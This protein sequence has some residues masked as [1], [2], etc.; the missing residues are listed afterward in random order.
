[1]IEDGKLRLP[2][3]L[4]AQTAVQSDKER[5]R[6]HRGLAAVGR[7][8]L[9]TPEDVSRSVTNGHENA[10]PVTTRQDETKREETKKKPAPR[11][12]RQDEDAAGL[13]PIRQ[14]WNEVAHAD[15]SRWLKTVGERKANAMARFKENPDLRF[16]RELFVRVSASDFLRGKNDRAWR[17][18]PEWLMKPGNLNKVLEGKYDNRATSTKG[19]IIN[20]QS[21]WGPDE[22]FASSLSAALSKTA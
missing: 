16:W 9:L 4:E 15:L 12:H 7:P 21:R 18:D 3:F 22:D 8:T 11:R 5:Q 2:K 6:K 1:V 13:E 10:G 19:S 17:A 14:L 20:G